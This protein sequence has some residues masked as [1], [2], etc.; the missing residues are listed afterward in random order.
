[1]AG[2]FFRLGLLSGDNGP[3]ESQE[4]IFCI[5]DYSV[6]ENMQE[7]YLLFMFSSCHGLRKFPT[8]CDMEITE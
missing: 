1:M 7:F 6:S 5:L 4:I 3:H 8:A 2:E